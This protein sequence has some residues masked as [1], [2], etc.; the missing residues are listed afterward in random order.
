MI[1]SFLLIGQSNMAGRGDLKEVS[2]ISDTRL[3]MM[4]NGRWQPLHEP[5]SS[6][7]PMAGASLGVSFAKRFIEEHPGDSAALIPCADGGTTL[8]EWHK[9]EPL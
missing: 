4:R 6:D 8:Q 5:V 9:G 3:L 2:P 1:Y 7:R